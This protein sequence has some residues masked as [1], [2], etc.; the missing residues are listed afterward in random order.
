MLYLCTRF[1]EEEAC[2]LPS[3]IKYRIMID[4]K[5]IEELVANY[6]QGRDVQLINLKVSPD[7]RILVEV[8][9][10][11][12]VDL[13]YCSALN[14]YLQEQLDRDAEDYELEV[15][16]VSITDPF[17]TKMQYEKHLGHDVEIL[18]KDG[19]KLHGVLVN[20]EE[21]HFE[22]DVEVLVQVEG[23]KKKEKQVQTQSFGYQ[24]VKYC[25]YDL[26][27]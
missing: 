20:V 5:Q 23:K 21:D 11:K 26:K 14:R 12:G 10:Y 3:C 15:G 25:K 13:D 9:A 19:R 2:G 18:T 22:A 8:D 7:N 16:S 4:P 27:V 24:D 6:V 1:S 17:R